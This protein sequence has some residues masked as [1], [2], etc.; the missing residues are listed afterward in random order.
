MSDRLP[1]RF[2]DLSSAVAFQAELTL[3]LSIAALEATTDAE[4]HT[5]LYE[6]Y[7]MPQEPANEWRCND[8]STSVYIYIFVFHKYHECLFRSGRLMIRSGF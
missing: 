6:F 8:T 1:H 2:T 3:L 5:T 7:P 4:P